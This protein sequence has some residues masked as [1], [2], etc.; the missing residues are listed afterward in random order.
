GWCRADHGASPPA[1][2]GAIPIEFHGGGYLMKS[3]ARSAVA[4]LATALALSATPADT[5]HAQATRPAAAEELEE[6]VVTGS[7]I[8]RDPL[9]EAAAVMEIGTADLER[10]GL[11]NL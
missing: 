7:R 5:A 10:T 4:A 8:R 9:D 6:V 2:P 11:T 3:L 1:G